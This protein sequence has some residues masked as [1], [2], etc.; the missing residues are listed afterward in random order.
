[1]KQ[2]VIRENEAG[3]RF[4]KYLA[5]LL[6]EAPKSFCY[7][8]LRKKNIT[9]NG[10]KATGNEKLCVGDEVKLFFSE[11]TFTKFCGTQKVKTAVC[12]LDVLYEDGNILL[13]NKPVGM[14]SQPDESGEPSLVEYLLG[15]LMEK[16]E[17]TEESLTTFRPSVCNRLDRNTSGLVAA[18]KSLRGL[19]ELS[20]MFHDRT[21]HKDYLCLVKGELRERKEIK[22]F[23]S[24]NEKTN[25]V[26]VFQTKTGDA[27]PIETSYVPLGSSNGLTLL[28]VR[29][30]T[31]RTHQIR[32][33]LSSI[34]H[35]IVG[36]GKYGEETW[37]RVF[38]RKYGLKHQLLHA[39]RLE[40]PEME[41]K[42]AY[43]SGKIFVAEVPKL[44][45]HII[46]EEQ[47]EESYHE[48]LERNLGLC[49]NDHLCG[50][51]SVN[52]K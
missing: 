8:M 4:D 16:G 21:M 43:Q 18:G 27:L 31:G 12:P 10:K 32:A 41:G 28:K 13:I 15:Y 38:R 23:L 51:R 3:Q 37:N 6:R 5:K 22:G 7:K 44:F 45:K 42:L 20:R 39:Y 14:R 47:L 25:K 50:D 30:V 26:T 19:Q 52:C 24:K 48:N 49:K 1:M 2:F 36:D 34:G 29:L 35:P 11:E 9:L 40:L 33:H 46:E 17:V